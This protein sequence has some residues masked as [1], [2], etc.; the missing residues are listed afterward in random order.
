MFRVCV[1][2][3]MFSRGFSRRAFHLRS[4][5]V[6]YAGRRNLHAAVHARRLIKAVWETKVAAFRIL[7]HVHARK[8]MMR[9]AVA[10]MTFGMTHSD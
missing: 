3:R 2:M 8:R 9:P 7:D 6:C 5:R 4:M 10:S 1:F